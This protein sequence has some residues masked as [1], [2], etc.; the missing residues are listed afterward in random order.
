[1]LSYFHEMR[2]ALERHG[3]TVEK[4]VGD[5]VLAV[6][7]V[8]EAHE[9][10]SLRACRAALEMQAR[11]AALNEEF[12][13]RFGT[14]IALRIG[15]NTGEVVTG[16]GPSRET[17][18]TGDP[19]NAAAR[20]EQAAGPGEVLLGEST[21]RLVRDAVRAEAV[22][23]LN[24]KGKS[25]PVRRVPAARG[26][27]PRADAAAGGDAVC[28]PRGRAPPA[29]ARARGGRRAA[30][31]PS[32]D[33][34]RRAGRGQVPP[35]RGVRLA[36][37]H[38]GAGRARRVP[39]LRRG[40]HLLGDR[41]DRAR[42]GRDPRR[43]LDRGGAGAD[44]G[45]RR[46]SART[47]P[48]SRRT[49]RSCSGSPTRRRDRPGD[50]VGD[51]PLPDR[52]GRDAAAGR[53]RRRHPL[54]RA[55]RCSICSPACRRRSPTHRSCCSASP[56][57][58]CSSTAP[59]G[60][61]TMRLE[62]LGARDGD[63]LLQSLLGEAPAAVRRTASRAPRPETRSSPRSWSRCCSTRACSASRTASAPWRATSTRSR[64]RRAC[65]RCSARAST[66]STPTPAPRSS[67]ARSR[68]RS[69]TAAPSSS[70]PLPRRAP[71]CR[72]CSR[73]LG[74][75]GPRPSRRGELRRR[76]RLPLQ[77]HPRPRRRL[78]GNREEA[79]RRRSTSSSRAG[80]SAR[81]ATA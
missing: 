55:R 76:V 43:A 6:F 21:Y 75:Q 36:G 52:P 47:G 60:T 19:V 73:S 12:E 33:G 54:G 15:V 5:A 61:S 20:L 51:P 14:R 74:G 18:V 56:G 57:P 40:D 46:G 22:E 81:P 78:P 66:G 71:P 25:E 7:G 41:R 32:R 49:S 58:S 39:L 28:G 24:A 42:A 30:R 35:D 67:A 4:F 2:G 10:D 1:M 80:S 70:S 9:D 3:G 50:G 79:P 27:R 69:S 48:S 59:T 63:A 16:D 26:R 11:L 77:A 13:R 53:R 8:P 31:M 65:T 62:P 72:P 23:P 17:F 34:R 38:A 64:C 44:R 68:A 45:P 29:R 37:R